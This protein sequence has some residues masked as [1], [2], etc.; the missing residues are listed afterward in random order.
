VA[1]EEPKQGVEWARELLR[2]AETLARPGSRLEEVR[3]RM[4]RIVRAVEAGEQTPGE[5]LKNVREL[6]E[7]LA[8]HRSEHGP[9]GEPA[10]ERL[11]GRMLELVEELEERIRR[12]R[13]AGVLGGD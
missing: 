1:E 9:D 3:R 6:E 8:L 11:A 12:R 4:G 7:E 5:A 13:G 10:R 2:R